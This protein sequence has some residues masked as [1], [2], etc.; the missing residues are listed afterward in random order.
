MPTVLVLWRDL[1]RKLSPVE[2]D[3]NFLNLRTTAD[4]VAATAAAAVITANTAQTT[5]NAAAAAVATK[6]NL[7]G[8]PTQPFAAAAVTASSG[9]FTSTSSGTALVISTLAGGGQGLNI[10][11]DTSAL[12][13]YLQLNTSGTYGYEFRN[14]SGSIDLKIDASG[15]WLPGGNGTQT[16]GSTS[17]RIGQ[18]WC[19]AGAFN[20]SDARLKTAVRPLNNA[21]IKAAQE[22]AAKVGL[23]QWLAAVDLKGPDGARLHSGLTVQDAIEILTN[24][25]LD[26]HSYA[27]IGYDKWEDTVVAHPAIEAVAAQPAQLAEYVTEIKSEYV[28]VDGEETEIRQ[29]HLVCIKEA[30]AA[31]EAIDAREAW[32]EITLKAGEAY[33][34]RYD[35]L[36]QFIHAGKQADN[37]ELRADNAELRADNAE[38]RARLDALERTLQLE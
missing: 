25:G 7:A 13:A 32:D 20:S 31:T 21:E 26:W 15:N 22:M 4:G 35:E 12:C 6:A 8:S 18:V 14:P 11:M 3:T 38:L 28:I 16:L 17:L 5:A 27:F 24:N 19:T 1:T 33:S 10:G 37:A 2:V 36:N 30:V 23:Y 34:F 9:V 29:Q